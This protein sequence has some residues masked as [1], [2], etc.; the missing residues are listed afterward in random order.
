MAYIVGLTATDGCLYTSVRKINFK[1]RDRDLV[2]T[3]L[4][5]LGRTNP[6]KSARTRSGG[7]V[8][9]TEFGDARLYRWLESVGVTPRKSLTLGAIAAPDEHLLAVAP[10]LL[11]GDGTILNKVYRADT[12]SRA[13]YYW[14][15]LITRFDS[16]SRSHLEW[17]KVAIERVTGIVGSITVIARQPDDRRHPFFNLRYEK[18]AS[19]QLLPLLYPSGAPCLER[20]KAIWTQYA[21]HHGL[22]PSRIGSSAQVM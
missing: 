5:L 18:R 3:Y 13:D 17:L 10:G 7:T 6:I 12:S 22:Q 14:E 9:F 20:K 16:A 4:S 1:S 11:D 8:F 15:Y 2:E 19:T 21:E